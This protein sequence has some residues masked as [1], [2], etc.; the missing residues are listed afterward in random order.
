MNISFLPEH[1]FSLGGLP[2]TNS[3]LVAWLAIA[4]LIAFAYFSTRKM[5]LVPKNKSQ[6]FAELI[7]E[8]LYGLV[9][10]VTGD[11]K[12]TKRFFPLVATIFLFVLLSNWLGLLPGVGSI[13]LFEEI[14]GSEEKIF[15]PL[16]R[17][18]SADLN[19]TLGLA[20]ISVLAIQFF[21]IAALGVFKYGKKFINF[22]SPILFVVGIL[23][24]VGEVAKVLSFSFRL[25][26]NVFAGEVLL[27]VITFLVPYVVPLPFYF[28][29]VVVGVIQAFI[30]SMLTAVFLKMA[31]TME[32]GH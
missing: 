30:F 11:D 25:F 3:L 20:I 31:V 19:F 16:F 26:G 32:E 24:M 17:A 5:E 22:K 28:L 29:E 23:E 6:H 18:G 8:S 4:I 2:I 10:G 1:L 9:S 15:V 21:G 14:H 7:V 27:I 13:G 12:Q